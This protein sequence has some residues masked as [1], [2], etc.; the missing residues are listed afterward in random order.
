MEGKGLERQFWRSSAAKSVFPAVLDR[1]HVENEG[2]GK[3][4]ME[5]F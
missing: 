5:S 2:S 4:S 1:P 3:Q